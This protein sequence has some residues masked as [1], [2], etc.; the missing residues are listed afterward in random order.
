MADNLEGM[1]RDDY[2]WF[3][4]KFR[5]ARPEL[6]AA[7][8]TRAMIV[9]RTRRR[10]VDARG[11]AFAPYAESTLKRKAR[12]GQSSRVTLTDTGQ[13]LDRMKVAQP[14]GHMRF[15]V[16]GGQTKQQAEVRFGT[17]RD[18]RIANYHISDAPRAKIPKRDFFGLTEREE[19][20]IYSQMRADTESIKPMD[21]RRRHKITVLQ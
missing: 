4:G 14:R 16:R 9:R 15:T 21:R 5:D 13:M 10:H 8:A 20:V 17:A 19:R 11:A 12:K 7:E 1:I 2:G 6:R 18:E 3:L